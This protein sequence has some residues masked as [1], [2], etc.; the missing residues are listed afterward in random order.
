MNVINRKV[1]E[2]KFQHQVYIPLACAAPTQKIN[3]TNAFN[4]NIFFFFT[5]IYKYLT[6]FFIEIILNRKFIVYCENFSW[7]KCEKNGFLFNFVDREKSY[8]IAAWIDFS[9]LFERCCDLRRETYVCCSGCWFILN[10]QRTLNQ[11]EAGAKVE[12]SFQWHL[13]VMRSKNRSKHNVFIL[14]WF[15]IRKIPTFRQFV[16][17]VSNKIFFCCDSIAIQQIRKFD[18]RKEF[19]LIAFLKY[20]RRFARPRTF[21]ARKIK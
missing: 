14:K 11:K 17:V 12:K 18:C 2:R 16:N 5:I 20:A 8:A 13:N 10:R 9:H 15:W 1:V 19:E 7:E 6:I 3:T 21:A 4:H